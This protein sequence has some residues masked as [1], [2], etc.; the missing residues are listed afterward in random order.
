MSVMQF[1]E[2]RPPADLL[3]T[4]LILYI[5]PCKH[6]QPG[7]GNQ[8]KTPVGPDR[9]GKINMHNV[10]GR[11]I[12]LQWME[13]VTAGIGPKREQKFGWDRPYSQIP[14]LRLQKGIFVYPFDYPDS[15]SPLKNGSES[16]LVRNLR[17]RAVDRFNMG[18]N[19]EQTT[20]RRIRIPHDQVN[21]IALYLKN[22]KKLSP[23]VVYLDFGRVGRDKELSF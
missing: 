17:F 9:N 21:E 14:R 5:F 18:E 22:D 1:H 11:E 16:W 7:D 6:I 20:A 13:N 8:N 10:L 12:G 2:L 4:D 3:S 19:A 23:A 15:N